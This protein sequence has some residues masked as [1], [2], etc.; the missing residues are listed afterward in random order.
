MENGTCP[1]QRTACGT[2]PRV[3]LG[4]VERSINR[5]FKPIQKPM[6]PTARLDVQLSCFHLLQ[7]LHALGSRSLQASQCGLSKAP[8]VMGGELPTSMVSEECIS[9]HN[10]PQVAL[11]TLQLLPIEIQHDRSYQS[12]KRTKSGESG[13]SGLGVCPC[14]RR[15]G[16]LREGAAEAKT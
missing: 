14:G 1:I 10:T 16:P 3:V 9:F 13:V 11:I 4:G 6:A 12:A 8:N 7:L 5:L 15:R 2:G